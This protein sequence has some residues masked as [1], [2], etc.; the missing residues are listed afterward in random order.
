MS[1]KCF[2]IN[3]IKMF[4]AEQES[5]FDDGPVTCAVCNQMIERVNWKFHKQRKHNNLAWG[6]GEKPIVSSIMRN[7]FVDFF[8]PQSSQNIV[9]TR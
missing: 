7:K 2:S 1:Y 3:V 6:V 4:S 5:Q 8:Y 9:Q